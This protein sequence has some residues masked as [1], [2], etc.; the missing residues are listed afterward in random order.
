MF[1]IKSLGI[2]DW[3]ILALGILI[4]GLGYKY[5]TSHSTI[6]KLGNEI[7]ELKK[8]LESSNKIIEMELTK[9]D[10]DSDSESDS[11]PEPSNYKTNKTIE[12]FNNSNKLECDN[13]M[14]WIKKPVPVVTKNQVNKSVFVP[15]QPQLQKQPQQ[16]QSLPQ[17]NNN[18]TLPQQ[19]QSLPQENNNFILPQQNNNFTLP[20]ENN[21][22]T[23]P[24]ENNNFILPQENNNFSLPQENILMQ[25]PPIKQEDIDAMQDI[26]SYLS[27]ADEVNRI[28][29]NDICIPI[30]FKKIVD[31]IYESP[32]TV[33]NQ[34]IKFNPVILDSNDII[35]VKPEQINSKIDLQVPDFINI[36]SDL[37]QEQIT[38]VL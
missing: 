19:K 22:F 14:C 7:E 3:I 1:D 12:T 32:E 26:T 30:D 4:I 23:L 8:K 38:N 25:L 9:S 31:Q 21:N 2:R 16:K 13:G 15:L 29:E 24:Q 35:E 18:F 34:E 6:K 5:W 17:E 36:P 27:M 10:S 20:Q 33:S 28:M 37:N 11:D